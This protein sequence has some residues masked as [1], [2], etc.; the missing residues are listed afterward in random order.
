MTLQ[1]NAETL[2]RDLW[3]I[4]A[5]ESRLNLD[6][7]DEWMLTDENSDGMLQLLRREAKI[8]S[9]TLFPAITLED[10]EEFRFSINVELG[11]GSGLAVS[12][13]LQSVIVDGVLISLT[14]AEETGR[15]ERLKAHRSDTLTR[16][17]RLLKPELP[18]QIHPQGY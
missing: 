13:L 14:G 3:A 4:N 17:K 2:L 12:S 1:L 5:L 18:S 11:S 6:E 16:L 7:D 10:E 9:G 8:A 15:Q